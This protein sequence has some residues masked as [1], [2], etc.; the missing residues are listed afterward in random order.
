MNAERKPS[1]RPPES[2]DVIEVADYVLHLPSGEEW[3][4]A[5]VDE[6]D[7]IPCGWPLSFAR[8]TDCRLIEKAMPETRLNLLR[9]LATM[10]DG[11]DPR[12]SG[13]RAALEATP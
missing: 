1:H 11:S 9:E 5:R 4:V 12:C 13:A 3:M 7:L 10:Q 8:P 2:T 6:R